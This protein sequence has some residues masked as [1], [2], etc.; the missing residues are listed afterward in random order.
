MRLL[1]AFAIG[2][3]FGVGVMISGMAN[4]AKVLN[5]F[6]VAGS[7]DPSLI[8]VMGGALVTT[9]IGYRLVLGR[10]SPLLAERFALPTASRIDARLIGGSALFGVGWGVAG[11]CPGGALPALGAARIEVVIFVAAL[12]A[13]ILATRFLA[14]SAQRRPSAASAHSS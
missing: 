6:D 13:G 3:L 12:I 8:F 5:F 2:L 1:S 14:N 10:P 9:F 4:P 7:W 11:F